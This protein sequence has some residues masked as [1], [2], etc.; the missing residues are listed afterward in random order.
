MSMSASGVLLVIVSA[1]F[2]AHRLKERK[3]K[4]FPIFVHDREQRWEKCI[5]IHQAEFDCRLVDTDVYLNAPQYSEVRLPNITPPTRFEEANEAIARLARNVYILWDR[6]ICRL[7]LRKFSARNACI[8][9]VF[10][11][12][13]NRYSR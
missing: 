11:T 5:C 6:T 9:I 4:I 12:L 3:Q 13:L 8:F 1:F 7:F 2:L 10:Q